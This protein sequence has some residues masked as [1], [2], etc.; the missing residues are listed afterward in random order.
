MPVN[1]PNRKEIRIV[2]TKTGRLS[3]HHGDGKNEHK[4][5][6]EHSA[7]LPV[8]Q[9]QNAEDSDDHSSKS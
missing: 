1:V 9:K 5:T 2:Q 3:G 8:E 4:E 6:L 7:C